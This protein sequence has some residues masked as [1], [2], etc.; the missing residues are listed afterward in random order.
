MGKKGLVEPLK[1]LTKNERASSVQTNLQTLILRHRKERLSKCSLRGL[2]GRRDLRFW[3]YPLEV[4]ALEDELLQCGPV[5]LLTPCAPVLD[6]S[7][8]RRPLLLLD[9][10]WRLAARMAH[11][12]WQR[13]DHLLVARSLPKNWITSYPRCPMHCPEHCQ[14]LASVEALFA[15]LM[16]LNRDIEGLLDGYLWKEPFLRRSGFLLSNSPRDS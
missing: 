13:S 11:H 15:A 12:L 5:T 4:S 14:G 10:T 2:E 7:D 1:K 9:G 8:D 6:S 3:T 16:T